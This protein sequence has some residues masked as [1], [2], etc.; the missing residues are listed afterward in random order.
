MRILTNFINTFLPFIK[1]YK[2]KYPEVLIEIR[3]DANENK[4]E[5]N[6]LNPI[7]NKKVIANIS[8]RKIKIFTNDKD[9]NFIRLI[10]NPFTFFELEFKAMRLII[11]NTNNERDFPKL[12]ED[13]YAVTHIN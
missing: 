8:K 11:E 5:I 6:I 12:M 9:Y 3:E 7:N 4:F 10:N 13:Q 1:K 2:E